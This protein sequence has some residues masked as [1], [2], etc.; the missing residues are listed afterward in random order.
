MRSLEMDHVRGVVRGLSRAGKEEVTNALVAEA[1]GLQTE[2]EK[3]RMRRRLNEMVRRNELIRLAPGRY[4]YDPK[5]CPDRRTGESYQR[6]WRAVR[7]AKPGFSAQDLSQVSRVGYT[8]VRRYLS[9][10]QEEGFVARFGANGN[11]L[12]YR[13]TAL[14]RD[15]RETPFPPR[16]IK[17]PFE[18]ERS[19]ACRLVRLFMDRDPYQAKGKIIKECRAILDR[20]EKS[21]EEAEYDAAAED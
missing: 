3:A 20:F 14:A 13:G 11:T 4:Q 17:D 5:A 19:A 12:L 18:T 7:S 21:T 1:L 8:Q 10:L 16:P 6:I 2:P 15:Q 9:W